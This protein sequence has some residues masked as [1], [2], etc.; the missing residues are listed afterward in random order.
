MSL[1]DLETEIYFLP[2]EHG[3]KTI[4]AAS[5][6]RTQFYH[7]GTDWGAQYDF[8]DVSAVPPGERTRA[9]VTF[10]FEPPE[11]VYPGRPFLVREGSKVAGYGSVVRIIKRSDHEV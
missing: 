11:D 5:G 3:G 6:Y 7:R 9:M 1:P 2:T 8:P 4:P 10:V